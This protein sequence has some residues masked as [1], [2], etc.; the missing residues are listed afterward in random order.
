MRPKRRERRQRTITGGHAWRAYARAVA[1]SRSDIDVELAKLADAVAAWRQHLRHE[2][3]FWP[4]LR[5]LV[6][7]IL[8]GAHQDD[9]TRACGRVLQMLA[10]EGIVDLDEGREV[11]AWL[12]RKARGDVPG[13]VDPLA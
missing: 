13:S 3:Q 12:R 1:K 7:P 6:T 11:V 2:A 9:V 5:A 8:D 10:E 4:Q